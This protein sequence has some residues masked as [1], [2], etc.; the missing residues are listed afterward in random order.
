MS[1]GGSDINFIL[2]KARGQ[3]YQVECGKYF[4]AKHKGSALIET[5]HGGITHPNQFFDESMKFFAPAD[6]GA[7]KVPH[8]SV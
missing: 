8:A 6:G 1:V 3:H 5:E 4:E 7:A 2:E